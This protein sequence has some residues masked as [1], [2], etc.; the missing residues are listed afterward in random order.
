MNN[1]SINQVRSQ[2]DK[3]NTTPKGYADNTPQ[4]HD[5]KKYPWKDEP[6]L[7]PDEDDEVGMA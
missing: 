5:E 4:K 7:P 1:Q 2:L 6:S 3:I